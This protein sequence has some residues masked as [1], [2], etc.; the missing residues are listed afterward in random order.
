M[1]DP[2]HESDEHRPAAKIDGDRAAPGEHGKQVSKEMESVSAAT[3]EQ[4]ASAQEI[5]SA[6]DSL[7]H[8][9][10]ELQMSLRKFQF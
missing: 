8:L 3:E 1:A 5:A 4:S 6:S 10:E 9:A 2:V 7:A